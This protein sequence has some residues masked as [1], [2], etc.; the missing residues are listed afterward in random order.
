MEKAQVKTV[1][2][3]G[4]PWPKPPEPKPEKVAKPKPKAKPP[5][6]DPSKIKRTDEN[7]ERWREKNAHLGLSEAL[8][9]TRRKTK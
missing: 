1:L 7:F 2:A 6:K 4:A 8:L 9:N 5:R 3:P